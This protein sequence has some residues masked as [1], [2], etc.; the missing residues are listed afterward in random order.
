[1]IS[2]QGYIDAMTDAA[3]K[4]AEKFASLLASEA[5]SVRDESFGRYKDYP[6]VMNGMIDNSVR[7]SLLT[8]QL[9]TEYVDPLRVAFMHPSECQKD[10]V[11]ELAKRKV[12]AEI[13]V[14]I[15][16]EIAAT[17][18]LVELS[19][20]DDGLIDQGAVIGRLQM[21]PPELGAKIVETIEKRSERQFDVV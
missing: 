2:T 19:Y 20:A 11:R 12:A 7:L 1:M 15:L 21:T 3:D 6:E 5:E 14:D 16:L 18:G 17:L 9:A 8:S 10:L 4:A 13:L